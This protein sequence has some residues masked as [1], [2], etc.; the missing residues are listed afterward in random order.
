M[1]RAMLLRYDFAVNA[2]ACPML[3]SAS[4]PRFCASLVVAL[5]LA[6]VLP[7]AYAQEPSLPPPPQ[8][9]E[10]EFP[11]SAAEETGQSPLEKADAVPDEGEEAS[12]DRIQYRDPLSIDYEPMGDK[13]N[14]FKEALLGITRYSLYDDQLRFRIGGRFQLDG[15]LISPSN[16]LTTTIGE[17]DNSVDFRRL[18]LFAEGI[19]KNMYFR[20]E[21]DFA[22]DAGFKSAY[23]EGREGGLAVWDV[24]LGKFRYGL[25]QEPFTLE[26]SMSTFDTT[27]VEVSMPLVTMG[28]G[29]NIGAMVYDASENRRFTWAAGAFSFGRSDNDN[30]ATSVLSLTGRFG[31]QPTRHNDGERM[32]HLGLSFSSRTPTND[33]ERYEAR[34]EA[35]FVRAFADTGDIEANKNTLFA[36]ET[37]WKSGRSWAQV[38]WIGSNL[39]AFGAGSL[40]FQGFAVQGGLFLTGETRPWDSLVGVWGRVRPGRDYHGGNPFKPSNGGAWEI[41]ARY[42]TV[43]LNDGPVQ[44]G[45]VR[46]LTLGVNWYV[47]ATSKLQFNWVPS[48]V[49]DKG[50]ANTWILRYQYAIM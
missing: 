34:P 7:G 4:V 9:A 17:T 11:G 50:N 5:V 8:A 35:R 46:N 41:A 21:A 26:N 28:P 10:G 30:A 1:F 39:D 18:R 27:F 6:S 44:G 12:S 33:K 23:L 31:F 40:K 15:T 2:N 13:W 22:A 38:E 24:L 14:R 37:A 3:R 36:L 25:F 19:F 32:L 47:N 49:E 29:S 43:D 20:A 16:G 42:S 48:R 45:Q